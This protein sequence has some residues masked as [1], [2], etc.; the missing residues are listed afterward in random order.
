M[1]VRDTAQPLLQSSRYRQPGPE[2]EMRPGEKRIYT[3][4]ASSFPALLGLITRY[5]I[6]QHLWSLIKHLHFDTIILKNDIQEK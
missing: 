6:F 2:D 3:E 5:L 4:N 1:R